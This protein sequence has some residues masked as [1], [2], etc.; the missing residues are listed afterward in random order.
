MAVTFESPEKLIGFFDEL[1]QIGRKGQ[2]SEQM[3]LPKPKAPLGALGAFTGLPAS[4]GAYGGVTGGTTLPGG[5][6]GQLMSAIRG[7]E[8]G[9]RYSAVNR[10]SGAMGAY[11]IMPSNI[12]GSGRGWDYEALGRDVSQSE[13]MSNPGIQDAIARYKL[14]Q[15]LKNWGMAGAAA[16]WY[17]GEWGRKNMYSNRPQGG[18]PSMAAYVNSILNRAR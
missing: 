3:K 5:S 11:Q 7:Q 12:A 1:S 10:D 15:Y 2:F 6:L 4:T 16:T 8:S 14:G 17:G 13:F 18:Y 9:G